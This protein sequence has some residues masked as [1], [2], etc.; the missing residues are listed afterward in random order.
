MPAESGAR[1]ADLACTYKCR[2]SAAVTCRESRLWVR[3][4]VQ[5]HANRDG[6]SDGAQ[7]ICEA[8]F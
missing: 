5:V 8:W 4:L 6:A 7:L 1:V 2:V 3:G